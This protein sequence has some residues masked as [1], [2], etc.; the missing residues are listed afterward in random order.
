MTLTDILAWYSAVISTLVLVCGGWVTIR[1]WFQKKVA[2]AAAASA[3][4]TSA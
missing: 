4:N 2:A 1:N 3:G